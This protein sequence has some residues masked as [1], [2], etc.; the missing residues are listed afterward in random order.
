MRFPGVKVG[1]PL[2]GLLFGLLFLSGVSVLVGEV[3]A[4]SVSHRVSFPDSREQVILVR[5]EFPVATAETELMMPAWTPGSYK[6]R[7]FAANVSQFSAFSADGSALDWRKTGKD[8]WQIE[9]SQHD[10]IV[11]EYEVFTNH[12]SVRTSWAS[13]AFML[14][15]PGSVLM[16]NSESR[17]MPQLVSILADSQRGEVF[18]SM[19]SM[20]GSSAFQAEDY[21]ELVDSPIVIA[22]A[23]SYRFNVENHEYV[24]VNA[25][26]NEFWDGEQAARDVGKIVKQTQWFWQVNPLEKPYWFL[27]LSIGAG[28]GLEHDH[29][30][31]M[32]TARTQTRTRSGYIKW[33]GLVAHEFF[34]VWNVRRMRPVELLNYDYQSE[35]YTEQLWLAEGFT[36]Y[37]DNLILSRAGL[38]TPK[39]Y[40]ELLA[41]EIHRLE[42]TPGRLVQSA[43][44]SSFDAWIKHYQPNGNTVNT[45]ISY[46][47][48]GA[49]MGFVLDAWLRKESRGRR[50]LDEVMRKMYGLYAT[51]G[52]R[53]EDFIQV[54]VEGGGER[55]G[56]FVRSLANQTTELDVDNALDW[57]GLELIRGEQTASDKGKPGIKAG[58][59]AIWEKDR[60][61]LIVKS[62]LS[63]SAGERAGLLPADEV[64]ALGGERMKPANHAKLMESFRPGEQTILL[65][66]R[67]GQILELEL[68]LESAMPEKFEIRLREGYKQSQLR[69]L[70]DLLGQKLP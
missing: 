53:L 37:Y 57:Y 35:Q 32:M 69:R 36:S 25:G 9:T 14:I 4:Q 51:Q 41:A 22:D 52:Y 16:Y 64:L 24:L 1:R 59:G 2:R 63:G 27:N 6:I 39:E 55:A 58:F 28:G 31:V 10:S 12:L 34:H 18:T 50:N 65:V 56:K 66:S 8:R 13:R 70:Q 54:V 48:K 45:A 67:R 17:S 29:S 11:V 68:T 49:I 20:E 7:D 43:G 21:D 42:T 62:V 5:S 46:Y 47:T 19:Q 23:P 44:E 26:E 61:E 30:T 3:R 15:N 33:L 60:T 38:I 40:M